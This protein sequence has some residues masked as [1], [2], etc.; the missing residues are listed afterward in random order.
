MLKLLRPVLW[1]LSL[2]GKFLTLTAL[3]LFAGIV[4]LAM[5]GGCTAPQEREVN[6]TEDELYQVLVAFVDIIEEGARRE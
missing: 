1:F 3:M 2:I 6:L 4:V 5:L